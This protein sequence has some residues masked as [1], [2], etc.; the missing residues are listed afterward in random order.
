MFLFPG[1]T[2]FF[3]IWNPAVL[4]SLWN[5][6]EANSIFESQPWWTLCWDFY[7]YYRVS[8]LQNRSFSPCKAYALLLF[9][10]Y[11][12]FCL[13]SLLA[14]LNVKC[15]GSVLCPFLSSLG[16]CRGSYP[17]FWFTCHLYAADSHISV[18]RSNC[19]PALQIHAACLAVSR[20]GRLS[21]PSFYLCF[22]LSELHAVPWA[23]QR[24]LTSQDLHLLLPLPGKGLPWNSLGGFTPSGLFL[25][26]HHLNQ[27]H[28]PLSLPSSCWFGHSTYPTWNDIAGLVTFLFFVCPFSW[29]LKSTSHPVADVLSCSLM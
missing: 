17:A 25:W 8:W 18:F 5:Q 4:N 13:F 16:L 1:H 19:A 26:A 22:S 6:G 10:L 2:D 14:F 27:P 23:C 7:T 12:W 29:V 21:A 9:L 28:L 11:K 20:E 15:L 24:I 3:L